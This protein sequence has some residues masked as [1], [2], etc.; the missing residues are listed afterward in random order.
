MTRARCGPVLDISRGGVISGRCLCGATTTTTTTSGGT[1][2]R[3]TATSEIL[4]ATGDGARAVIA[5]VVS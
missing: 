4:H 1:V 2:T 3:C 5:R